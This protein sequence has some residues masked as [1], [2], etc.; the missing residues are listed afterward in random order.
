VRVATFNIRH[1][2]PEGG[3]VDHRALIR[4]CASFDA[5]VLGLQEVEARHLR[6]WFR[7]QAALV[8]HR[9]GYSFVY[10]PVIRSTPLGRYGNA[11]L[12]RG[13]IGDVELLPLV[14]PSPR[15][16]RGAILA[17]V[18]LSSFAVTVAVT[19]LQHHG[20]RFRDLP[21]EAPVQLR[22]LLDALA[23]RPS[24]RILLGDLNLGAPNAVPILTE[25]GFAVAPTSPTFP[26]NR[27]RIT[28]DYV[29]V[30]GLRVLDSEV[31]P[32]F[33]SDHRA[34]VASV[35]LTHR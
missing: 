18:E 26:A 12:A 15:Q 28:L 25:A 24:P 27:P 10:G 19:H 31:V 23:A 32:T 1:G 17:R 34:V 6:S 3:R 13:R 35:E 2:A 29:A 4:T 33:T 22:G 30:D 14:R 8:A 21:P 5:D 11:L 16:P 7:D 20:H 9:L